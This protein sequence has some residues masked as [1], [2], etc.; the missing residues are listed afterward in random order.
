MKRFGQEV[1]D[2]AVQRRGSG[3]PNGPRC[4]DFRRSA[5]PLVAFA[6]LLLIVPLASGAA[7]EYN[8]K[9]EPGGSVHFVVKMT[10]DDS[11]IRREAV[12]DFTYGGFP[13]SCGGEPK[14]TSGAI[15]FPMPLDGK[16]RFAINVGRDALVV[17]GRLR[18]KRRAEGT[19]RVDGRVELDSG[20]IERC[21]SPRT[22]WRAAR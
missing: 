9:F 22:L 2:K 21:S 18:G 13:V 10:R 20:E 3:Q 7:R 12:T 6:A 1:K 19:F 17:R 11:E 8:G 16:R 14:T 15:E 4:I 5:L